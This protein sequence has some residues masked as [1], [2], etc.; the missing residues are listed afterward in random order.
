MT[1]RQFT[2]TTPIHAIQY[3]G[4]RQSANDIAQSFGLAVTA[5]RDGGAAAFRAPSGLTITVDEYDRNTREFGVANGCWVWVDKEMELIGAE[6][7]DYFRQHWTQNEPRSGQT[8][9]HT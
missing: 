5:Q 9:P 2:R 4:T 8:P 6:W 7:N 1:V 3:L